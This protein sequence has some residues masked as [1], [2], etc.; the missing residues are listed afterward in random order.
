MKVTRVDDEIVFSMDELSEYEVAEA[1]RCITRRYDVPAGARIS[2]HVDDDWTPDP[3][4]AMYWS[5]GRD[6]TDG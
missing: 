5:P 2:I 3:R 1:V 6:G 4:D